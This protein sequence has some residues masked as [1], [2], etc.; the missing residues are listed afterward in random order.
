MTT[1]SHN[2][3][4]SL[5]FNHFHIWCKLCIQQPLYRGDG[6]IDAPQ[7]LKAIPPS[8]A[9]PHRLYD[10]V[11]VSPSS[12]SDWSLH[13]IEGGMVSISSIRQCTD[14]VMVGHFVGHLQLIFH[15]L[16]TNYLMAYVH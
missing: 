2:P 15:L 8:P 6:N 3:H 1:E 10:T 16:Q 7:T 13:G 4:Y 14:L 11:I 5:L 9:S 12:E